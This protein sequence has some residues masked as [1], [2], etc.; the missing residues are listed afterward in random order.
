MMVQAGPAYRPARSDVCCLRGSSLRGVSLL[1]AV[2]FLLAAPIAARGQTDNPPAEPAPK[3][4]PAA[5]SPAPSAAAP[6]EEAKKDEA[7]LKIRILMARE[8]RE[9]R[10]P[11]LSLLDIPP[12]DDGVA[13]AKLAISDNNTT[14]RFLKQEFDL[15]IVQSAV[16]AE[17]VAEVTKRVDGGVAYVVTDASPTTLLALSDA[18]K[19]KDAVIFN[20]S[21]PDEA[22]RE[23]QCRVNIKHTAPSRS[24]L[25]DALGQ[26]MAWKQWRKWLL[27]VGPA[28]EDKLYADAIRR[29]AKRFG[30]KIVEERTFNYDPGSRRSDGGFEQ[31]QQQIPGFMQG[32]PEHDVVVIADEGDLFGEYFPYR[33]WISRPVVGTAGLIATS[34]H[35]AIELWG[36]TQFQNRFKRLAGRTMRPLDYNVW[37]AVRS[38][39][40]AATRKNTAD[41]KTLIP[42]MRSPEFE[43]AAFKGQKVTYRAWN[44]QLRQP[45]LLATPKI[46]V[47]VSPQQGFLH[48]VTELDTLGVD[49]PETKCTAFKK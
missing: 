11:P 7:T 16:P 13:G 15:D 32:A 45:I 18:L 9:D 3:E 1:G 40:E 26:Y 31:I 37:A 20:A 22:L 19:D 29:T 41:A 43:L 2:L 44:G 39:G 47:S 21:A 17:L 24:M 10:L 28:P 8:I 14:G 48:Q 35:P 23:E 25:A 12:P 38:V 33:T 42:Y 36:G 49:Q 6:N 4:A 27:V 34:W 30:H 46:L 5:P